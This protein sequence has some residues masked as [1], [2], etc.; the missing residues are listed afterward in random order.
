MTAGASNAGVRPLGIA[1]AFDGAP[2]DAVKLLAALCMLVDHVNSVVLGSGYPL[3]W[4]IGRVSFPLFCFAVACNLARGAPLPGYL[5][6]LLLFGVL[7]QPI[8]GLAFR[9]HDQGN[10][11]IALALG[12]L[13]AATLRQRGAGLQHA[14][15]AL[16]SVLVLVPAL[17]ANTG[18]EF[19]LAGLLLIAVLLLLLDGRWSTA[20]WLPFIAFGLNL[21]AA[22]S[23]AEPWWLGPLRDAAIALAGGALV[24]AVSLLLRGRRRF[25]PR[26]ALHV[27]YPGHLLLLAAIRGA[28]A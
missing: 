16:G 24:L 25:L 20:V 3:M 21:P 13:V 4:R 9:G 27:F 6:R 17:R 28:V 19:G 1:P 15:L 11:L 23:P 10:V 7:T 12:A 26:Y 22:R 8:F 2:L 14:L 5:R 18:F